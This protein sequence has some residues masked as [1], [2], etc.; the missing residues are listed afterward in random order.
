M[1]V[2]EGVI[3]PP[4]DF[5]GGPMVGGGFAGPGGFAGGGAGG[6]G[7]GGI[8]G[9]GGLLGIAGLAA[10]VAALGDDDDFNPPNATIIVP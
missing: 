5:L 1:I 10:G 7:A 6:G 3:G 4:A 2:E 9:I 8:G